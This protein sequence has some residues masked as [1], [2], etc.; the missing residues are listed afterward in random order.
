[1]PDLGAAAAQHEPDLLA[2]YPADQA[3]GAGPDLE[4]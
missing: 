2:E 4:R 1:M 3:G